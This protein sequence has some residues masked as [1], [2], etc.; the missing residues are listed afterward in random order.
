M[1]WRRLV[2]LHATNTDF[3]SSLVSWRSL[4]MVC[5]HWY[6]HSSVLS[7]HGDVN[8]T[9]LCVTSRESLNQEIKITGF[10]AQ[11]RGTSGSLI[12]VNSTQL[13][14]RWVGQF[15]H[16][17]LN[18]TACW[19]VQWTLVRNSAEVLR[20][21]TTFIILHSIFCEVYNL[22]G[23]LIKMQSWRWW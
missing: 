7:H 2:V 5:K 8:T 23:V 14:R 20:V 6:Q 9:A 11:F 22:T 15:C 12:P 16:V 18:Y 21:V 4:A 10:A 1:W 3:F 19:L 13:W 17:F